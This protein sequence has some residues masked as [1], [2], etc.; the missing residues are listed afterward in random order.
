MRQTNAARDWNDCKNT[1]DGVLSMMPLSRP[2]VWCVDTLP[3]ARSHAHERTI[4]VRAHERPS[5]V[6]VLV[7]ARRR[8]SSRRGHRER[9]KEHR[10]RRHASPDVCV[11]HR[12]VRYRASVHL[13]RLAVGAQT[14][15]RVSSRVRIARRSRR[16]RYDE[17]SVRQ[18]CKWKQCTRGP[19]DEK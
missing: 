6:R 3:L 15:D 10:R 17:H 9:T 4:G 7:R 12:R 19:L 11:H 2:R 14:R 18:G 5:T 8:P 13:A 1:L 16:R